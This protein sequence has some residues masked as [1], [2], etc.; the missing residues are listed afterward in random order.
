MLSTLSDELT[1][2]LP[3]NIIFVR[4]NILSVTKLYFWS[5]TDLEWIVDVKGEIE[6]VDGSPADE[7]DQADTNQDDVGLPSPSIATDSTL[8]VETL[9]TRSWEMSAN[10]EVDIALIVLRLSWNLRILNI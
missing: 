1:H 2:P 4:N 5:Y 7:E 9:N 6:D 10:R 3:R 8:C